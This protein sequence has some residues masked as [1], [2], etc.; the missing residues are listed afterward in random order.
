VTSL[1][2]YGRPCCVNDGNGHEDIPWRNDN[3]AVSIWDNGQIN[4]AHGLAIIP[5][6]WHIV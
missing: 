3:D 4:N 6:D 1:I 5:S 2:K